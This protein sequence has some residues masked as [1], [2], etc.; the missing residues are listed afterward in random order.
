MAPP[1]PPAPAAPPGNA[2]RRSSA[3]SGLDLAPARRAP[4]AYP[5]R[6]K[7]LQ[8][9]RSS[10]RA[11]S[12]PPG[13]TSPSPPPGRPRFRAPHAALF[14][15]TNPAVYCFLPRIRLCSCPCFYM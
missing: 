13:H 8:S 5:A 10:P 9:Y 3:L 1:L 14:P 4:P 12:A 6:Y 7:R 15:A 2:Y 11:T